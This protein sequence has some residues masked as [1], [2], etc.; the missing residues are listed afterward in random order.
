MRK[1]TFCLIL[2]LLAVAVPVRAMQ[3]DGGEAARKRKVEKAV[4]M[5]ATAAAEAESLTVPEN[6]LRI[7]AAAAKALWPHDSERARAIFRRLA[8]DLVAAY[9]DIDASED[10]E[11]PRRY[12]F[13]Q[14]RLTVIREI[15]ERDAELALDA[16]HRTHV[17]LGGAGLDGYDPDTAFEAELAQRIAQQNP[18]RTAEIVR[19]SLDR[20]T[21][22]PALNLI[23]RI[24]GQ[25]PELASELAGLAV[26]RLGQVSLTE[27]QDALSFA[28]SL[29]TLT[30]QN[31][32]D[33]PPQ[34]EAP[35]PLLGAERLRELIG[36]VTHALADS[37]S[38]RRGTIPYVIVNLR[39]LIEPIER[40][41]PDD[42]A[43]LR[44]TLA[45][46]ES[47][48]AGE[49]VARIYASARYQNATVDD[50]VAAS[51][52]APAAE[53]SQLISMAVG[54]SL[55]S[56]DFERARAV[57]NTDPD[58]RRRQSLLTAVDRM[59]ASH[60]IEAGRVNEALAAIATLRTPMERVASLLNL[61]Q[62]VRSQGDGAAADGILRQ[63]DDLIGES[64]N[65]MEMFQQRLH[66]AQSYAPT[67]AGRAFAIVESSVDQLNRMM[68]AAEVLS[69]FGCE[70]AS[71]NGEIVL[72]QP[73][74]LQSL[75]DSTGATLG[76][77][78]SYDFDRA[79][80]VAGR[81][82]KPEIRAL[83]QIQVAGALLA[84]DR[85]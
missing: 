79:A 15:A 47:S 62:R 33:G 1:P 29:L 22:Y 55:Q 68:H 13:Q 16:L 10:D 66:L 44:R 42:G 65:G 40:L 8:E 38:D 67:D 35:A 24:R 9:N 2:V 30:L 59:A 17:T 43:T 56:G 46:F 49:Q 20:G 5:I 41:S 11:S 69:G 60:V 72:A 63:V 77:L 75:A 37:G 61:A 21:F 12:G 18:D 71:R 14:V 83:V 34:E 85:Q 57:A 74:T 78:T 70:F 39:G 54:R 31:A 3:D 58:P 82:E 80:A 27:K 48:P 32:P 76:L 84:A 25:K 64:P 51:E 28:V 52:T 81:F 7:R 6:R 4:S 50:L 53:R 19:A 26:D 23:M 73:S 45:A 36:L